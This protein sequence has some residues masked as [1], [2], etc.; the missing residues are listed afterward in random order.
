MFAGPAF[1]VSVMVALVAA[2]APGNS[3]D[4]AGILGICGALLAMLMLGMMWIVVRR[5]GQCSAAPIWGSFALPLALTGLCLKFM[6]LGRGSTDLHTLAV[7]VVGALAAFGWGHVAAPCGTVV[8]VLAAVS[9][10]LWTSVL[11]AV[12]MRWDVP[13]TIVV[14]SLLVIALTSSSLVFSFLRLQDLPLEASDPAD[15]DWD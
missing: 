5:H 1:G 8:R 6:Y 2:N 15:S 13:S 14:F 3:G 7:L 4:T 11:I 10:M 12:V 9:A